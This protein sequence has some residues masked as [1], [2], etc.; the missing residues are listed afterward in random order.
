MAVDSRSKGR[1]QPPVSIE[2]EQALLGAILYDNNAIHALDGLKAEH[3]YEPLHQRMFHEIGTAIRAGRL[4]DPVLL[5]AALSLDE[6]LEEYGGFAYLADLY[7]RAPPAANAPDYAR[8]V[9]DMW[10]RRQIISA[11]DQME[12]GARSSDAPAETVLQEAERALLGLRLGQGKARLISVS[13]AAR[14]VLDELDNPTPAQSGVLTGLGP[15]DKH[16][17]PL[18]PGDMV[19]LA[20]RPGAGK[21]AMAAVMAV[22]IACP[23]LDRLLREEAMTMP[24]RGVIEINGEMTVAQMARR[25]LTDMA[26][27]MNPHDA[28]AYADIRRRRITPDQRI[29]L[30]RAW[31]LLQS[32][33]LVSVKRTGLTIS[34]V[35]SMVRRQVADWKREGIELGTVVIDHIGLIQAEGRAMDRYEASS[36]VSNRTKELAE[37][38]EAPV[39]ALS[40][41]SRALEQRDNKRPTLPDLRETGHLEQDADAVIGVYR[42]AYYADQE[43]EP[44][45][46]LAWAEWDARRKSKEIECLLLKVREGSRGVVRLWGD[47]PTN[48]IRASAPDDGGF[49]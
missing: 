27:R 39:I 42:D 46:D 15:L 20:G 22:N 30:E 38:V 9:T 3:F 28:P 24:M 11:A 45:K 41:L 34:E 43:P 14:G 21:S 19:I 36:Q 10:T 48:A 31:E 47:M 6:A 40:Q 25:H 8:A 49:L 35:R 5:G 1:G 26:Q 32:I 29:R 13:E 23:D 33:P 44:K 4:A 17:G 18:L 37:E 16:L 7:D 12:V 2:A